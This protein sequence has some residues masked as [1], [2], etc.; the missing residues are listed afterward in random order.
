MLYLPSCVG[1]P[2][3]NLKREVLAASHLLCD[4][5]LSPSVNLASDWVCEA[6]VLWY[7]VAPTEAE[8][9]PTKER[10]AT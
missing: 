6:I 8:K 9:F 5:R 10:K 7:I 4:G 3:V 1:L 2:D